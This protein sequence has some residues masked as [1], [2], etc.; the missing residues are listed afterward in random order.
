VS[1]KRSP[2]R[3]DKWFEMQKLCKSKNKKIPLDVDTRWRS[4][5]NMLVVAMEYQQ[6]ISMISDFYQDLNKCKLSRN[7]FDKLKFVVK[8]LET[9][10][11]FS[12]FFEGER[13]C[14][15]FL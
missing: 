15:I 9:F 7:E 5:Y 4:L 3:C 12:E 10:S 6:E 14:T 8:F 2:Q 11:E 1:I 13:C